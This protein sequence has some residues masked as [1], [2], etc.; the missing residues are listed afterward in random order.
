V[1]A[2]DRPGLLFRITRAL[3]EQ[4]LSIARARISTEATRAIDSFYVR[5]ADGSKLEASERLAAV[6]AAIREAIG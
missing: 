6:R 3:S 2:H 4:G 5:E 1:F